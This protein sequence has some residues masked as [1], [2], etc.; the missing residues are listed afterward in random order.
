MDPGHRSP[1]LDGNITVHMHSDPWR[2]QNPNLQLRPH[3]HKHHQ[4]HIRLDRNLPIQIVGLNRVKC[5]P[6][7]GKPH[8]DLCHVAM[9]MIEPGDAGARGQDLAHVICVDVDAHDHN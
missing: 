5:K 6:L 2:V 7:R 9:A 3:I 4:R 1:G 8:R